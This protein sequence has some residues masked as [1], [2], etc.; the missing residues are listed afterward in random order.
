MTKRKQPQLEGTVRSARRIGV[1]PEYVRHL[2]DRGRL[3]VVHK[4][5]DGRRFFDVTVIER[6]ARE[7]AAKQTTMKS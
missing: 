7:R 2:A 5:I 4:T 3:P 1:T 6:F